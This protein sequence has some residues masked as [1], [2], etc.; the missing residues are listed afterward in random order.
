EVRDLMRAKRGALEA[1]ARRLIEK[2]TM[3]GVELR[4][5]LLAHGVV[6]SALHTGVLEGWS[7]GD[8]GTELGAVGDE[9]PER[10]NGAAGEHDSDTPEPAA[11]ARASLARAAGSSTTRPHHDAV[12]GTPA[13]SPA[14][15]PAPRRAHHRAEARGA[16]EAQAPGDRGDAGLQR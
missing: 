8:G 16:A 3:E 14:P 9:H 7:P 13:A 4:D 5:L 1:V 11:R 12:A 15:G 6:P 2:E 10:R